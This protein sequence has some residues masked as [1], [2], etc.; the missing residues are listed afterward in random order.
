MQITDQL[1]DNP[2]QYAEKLTRSNLKTSESGS[3]QEQTVADSYHQAARH[4]LH[5]AGREAKQG[6]P[7]QVKARLNDAQLI[8]SRLGEKIDGDLAANLIEE[9]WQ[10][11]FFGARDGKNRSYELQIQKSSYLV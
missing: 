4:Y 11:L 3:S 2:I 1:L 5:L 9:A 6:N 10:S 8:E 7:D